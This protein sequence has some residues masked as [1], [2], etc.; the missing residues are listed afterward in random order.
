MSISSPNDILLPEI[1][2]SSSRPARSKI[3]A[4]VPIAIALF[5]VTAILFGGLSARDT[6]TSELRTAVDPV[7]TGS[8]AA[9]DNA[10]SAADRLDH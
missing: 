8:I 6:R 9:D 5:G 7:V 3:A 10:K 4:F 2:G 1:A